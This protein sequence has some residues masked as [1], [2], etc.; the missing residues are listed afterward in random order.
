[1]LHLLLVLVPQRADHL[2]QFL[3]LFNVHL[4]VCREL[5]AE[6]LLGHSHGTGNKVTQIVCQIGVDGGN[7]QFIAEIAV[8]AKGEGPEQE[9]PQGIHAK[10]LRQNI[11][12]HHVALTL[13]H[14]AAVKEQ[15]AVAVYL[16]G[17][18]QVQ[19]HEHCRPNDRVETDDFLAHKVHIGRPEF[20]Q[21]VL[22]VVAEAQRGHIVKQGV[23]PHVNHVTLVK[24]HGNTPREAGTGYAQI[25][26]ARL[27]EVVHH[28]VDTGS[29]L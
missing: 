21:A 26:K 2:H 5:F 25:L 11:G 18:G 3:V 27:N 9:E 4:L 13:T 17:Q 7:Q 24:V 23:N 22:L 16:L 29:G 12:V 19:A 28:L 1:M 20:V 8:R 14:L 10:A 6:I 15:P